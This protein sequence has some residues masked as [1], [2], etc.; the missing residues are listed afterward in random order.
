V[1]TT[2]WG[3]NPTG[4]VAVT[5]SIAV[6]ITGAVSLSSFVIYAYGPL[7]ELLW[8]VNAKAVDET[9]NTNIIRAVEIKANEKTFSTSHN[10]SLFIFLASNFSLSTDTIINYIR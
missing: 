4:T 5:V 2:S 8:V 6:S 1:T 9:R 10:S 7:T 3:R